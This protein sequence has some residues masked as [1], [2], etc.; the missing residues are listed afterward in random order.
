MELLGLF[1]PIPSILAQIMK[2]HSPI[3]HFSNCGIGGKTRASSRRAAVLPVSG[4]QA[5]RAGRSPHTSLDAP[6]FQN[7]ELRR[8]LVSCEEL[9]FLVLLLH[10]QLCWHRALVWLPPH[11]VLP[12]RQCWNQEHIP[13]AAPLSCG[14]QY[15]P[16]KPC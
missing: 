11:S 1:K 14:T 9:V 5:W 12:Q 10:Q 7:T 16:T 4:I 8:Y 3:L 2:P 6:G 15:L 13:I